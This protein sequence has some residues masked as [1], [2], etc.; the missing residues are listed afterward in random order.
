MLGANGVPLHCVIRKATPVGHQLANPA[1]SLIYEAPLLGL[2]CT[3]DNR[4]VCGIIKQSAADAQNWDWI[5]GLNRAQDGR[6]AVTLLQTHFDGPREVEKRIAHARDAMEGLHHT[7][8]SVFP[9]SSCVTGLNACHATLAQAFDPASD[10][11]KVQKMPQGIAT[12]NPSL[13]AAMQS[14]RSNPGAKSNFTA[15]LSE[16]SEQIALMF[17][18]EA[19]RPAH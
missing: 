12:Q 10:R 4:K 9:F 5:K 1:E 13:I 7:K 16:L 2:A 17:P 18:G 19:R 11:D 14:I 3:E 6:G 8:E 15:A